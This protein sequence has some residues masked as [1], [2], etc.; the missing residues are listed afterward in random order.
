M[1]VTKIY[2]FSFGSIKITRELAQ[3]T[4]HRNEFSYDQL[5]EVEQFYVR[6]R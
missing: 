2:N 4:I 3:F 1:N 6:H 5:E